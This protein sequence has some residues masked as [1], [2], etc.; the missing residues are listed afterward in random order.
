MYG[1]GPT[2]VVRPLAAIR[3]G[4]EMRNN[5]HGVSAD[6][7][8]VFLEVARSGQ[9]RRAGETL[10][11]SHTTVARRIEALERAIGGRLLV[12]TPS[13][14]DLTS[15]GEQAQLVAERIERA[16]HQL[17]RPQ[18][19]GGVDDVVRLSTPD[20]FSVFV[21]A[22]AAARLR[23]RH[24]RLRLEVVST[25]RPA[26]L[27]RSGLDIEVVA[28]EPRVVRAETA[29]LGAYRLGLFGSR[30]Y[31]ERYGV[32][33]E[34]PDLKQ[35]TLVYFIS[36]MLQI[37]D[38]DIGCQIVP[39]MQ[40]GVTSTNVFVHLAATRSGAGLGLLPTFLAQRHADLVRVL[41]EQIDTTV[42]YW[43]VTRSEALRRPAVV[44]TVAELRRGALKLFGESCR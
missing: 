35:H 7:L 20:A 13:G 36:S 10:G 33:R 28:G 21:A 3:W 30:D 1:V 23:R 32:P 27:H 31:L 22:P 26:A 15:L 29:P 14:W 19:A 41:P 39:Q 44:E 25:T 17:P 24:P 42:E 2:T 5:L 4:E 8:L 6:E 12:K 9:H 11:L 43:L 38:L 37:D 34:I 18:D 16:V 40:D